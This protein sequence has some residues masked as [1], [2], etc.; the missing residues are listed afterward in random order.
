MQP[1]ILASMWL[2]ILRVC[3]RRVAAKIAAATPVPRLYNT[4]ANYTRTFCIAVKRSQDTRARAPATGSVLSAGKKNHDLHPL[5]VR[6]MNISPWTISDGS[7]W[8]WPRLRSRSGQ[9]FL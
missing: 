6:Q 1:E 9:R 3:S 5:N 7:V 2:S 4:R 8:A